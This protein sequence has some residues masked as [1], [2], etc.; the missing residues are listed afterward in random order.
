MASPLEGKVILITGG[1]GRRTC[2]CGCGQTPK[3]ENSKYCQGHSPITLERNSKISHSL[4]GRIR[5][6]EHCLAISLAKKGKPQPNSQKEKVRQRMIFLASDPSY[7][8]SV[9]EGVIRAQQKPGY[10]EKVSLGLDRHYSIPENRKK[11]G[12]EQTPEKR[13]KNRLAQRNRYNKWTDEDWF[14][15]RNTCSNSARQSWKS[16]RDRSYLI[17]NLIGATINRPNKKEEELQNLLNTAFPDEW[18]YIGN[19]KIIINGKRPDFINTNGKRAIIEFFGDYWH[20]N[21][22]PQDRIDIFQE[23]GYSTLVIWEH[24]LKFPNK[25]LE[26]IGEWANG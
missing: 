7:I 11:H 8:K 13:E 3:L 4:K 19:G 14:R 17:Y 18:K 25:I 24:E 23:V 1:T 20:R 22:N 5:T 10:W 12:H 2:S 26:K 16:G 15:Y 6:P 21:D 9:R